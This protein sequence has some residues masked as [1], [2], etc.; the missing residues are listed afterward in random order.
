MRDVRGRRI[1]MIFQEPATSLNPVLTIGSQ[2]EEVLERHTGARGVVAGERAIALLDSVVVPDAGRRVRED[3]TT[4]NRLYAIEGSPTLTGAMADHRLAAPPSR[5]EAL[6]RALAGRVGVNAAGGTEPLSAAESRWLEAVAADLRGHRGAA[7]VIAGQ[8]QPPAVHALAHAMNEALGAVGKTVRYLEPVE[9]AAPG[10]LAELAADMH[11]GKVDMLMILGGNPVYDAPA[12]LEF[13]RAM[14][15]VRLR[16]RLGLYEDETSLLSH[17][18]LP[19]AHFLETWGDARAHDGTVAIIQPLIEPLYA[20]RPAIEVLAMML[21]Q[22]TP[23]AYDL[24]R[25]RWRATWRGGD[26]DQA[27]RTALLEGVLAG[28]ALPE[29]RAAVRP[30]ALAPAGGKGAKPQGLELIF[31]PDYAVWD[32]RYANNAWLQELPRPLTKITWDNA[33]L[34]SPVTARRLGLANGDTVELAL[35]GRRVKAPVWIAAGH[36]DECVTVHLGYGRAYAGRVGTG[37]GFNAYAL[38]TA[39]A[40]WFTSGLRASLSTS[41]ASSLYLRK[42]KWRTL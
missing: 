25:N 31:R 21:G 12:D 22:S 23:A 39:A 33:A 4:M 15:K 27:W 19:E 37:V 9:F 17:W 35:G 32:G 5:V 13:A 3:K 34:L 11:A 29:R 7:L 40:P 20:G 41:V 18:H 1:A 24:V 10:T 14:D 16:V 36:A 30:A 26:F 38:R 8:G 28:T 6:A 42:L 2:L